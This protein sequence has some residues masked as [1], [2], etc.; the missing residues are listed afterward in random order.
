[1]PEELFRNT[2]VV[3]LAL[4]MVVIIAPLTE[5]MFFRGFIFHGLWSRFGFWPAAVGS[6][7]LFAMVH[8][9]GR[10][11]IGLI[12]PFTIL[13]IL[14]AA[15]VRRTGSLWNSIAVHFLFNAINITGFLTLAE[16]T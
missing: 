7:W 2:S 16:R 11:R 13:G 8:V 6:G 10:D 12:V 5:E 14:F 15:L 3:P 9:T 1:M 4:F